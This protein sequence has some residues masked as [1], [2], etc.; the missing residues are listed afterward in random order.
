MQTC[1]ESSETGIEGILSGQPGFFAC[2]WKAR[3]RL[4]TLARSL[5]AACRQDPHDG[6]AAGAEKTPPA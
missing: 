6:N 3:L 2:M 5:P 4:S 1:G